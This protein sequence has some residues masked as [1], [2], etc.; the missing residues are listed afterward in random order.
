ME[1]ASQSQENQ[2]AVEVMP[3]PQTDH[4]SP[5]MPPRNRRGFPKIIII[6][7]VLVALGAGGWFLLKEPSFDEVSNG[8]SELSNLPS[9]T[10]LPTAT[11]QSSVDKSEVTVNVLNGTGV[12]GEASFLKDKLV[13]LGFADDNID[14]GNASSQD[15]GLTTT[16][17]SFSSDLPE[18]LVSEVVAQLESIYQDVTQKTGSQSTDIVI[19]TGLRKGQSPKPSATATPTAS[20][21]PTPTG[22]AS[23]TPS[24]TT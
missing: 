1:D 10:P 11:P 7:I 24:P 5:A 13:A 8:G 16:T 21:S 2:P 12:G 22:S 6:L 19:T 17:V 23:P 20:P 18:D 4:S 3:Q 9:P 15:G 14:T